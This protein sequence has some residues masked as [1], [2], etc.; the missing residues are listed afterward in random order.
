MKRYV[1]LLRGINVGGKNKVSMA[2]L[3]Q[4]FED[5]G[6]SDVSTYINSGNVLLQSD[7]RAAEIQAL[8]ERA[9]PRT[10]TLDSKFIK[11]LALTR[12]QL[13][14]VIDEKPKSFGEQPDTYYSDVIFLIGITAKDALAVFDPR[15]GVDR[16]WRGRGV[17]YS[18]RLSAARTKSRLNKIMLSPLYQSMTIR[19]WTTTTKLLTLLKAKE[20]EDH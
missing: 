4:C 11:V 12:A 3:R 9:L 20:A 10:F 14:A 18:Q 15:K 8:V 13:Q 5:L 19:S 1:V 17:V 16:V 2:G 6:F 7:K